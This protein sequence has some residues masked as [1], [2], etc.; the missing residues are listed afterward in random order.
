MASAKAKLGK[1]TGKS[2]RRASASR[3]APAS[4]ARGRSSAESRGS[5]IRDLEGKAAAIDRAQAVIEFD[6]QGNVLTANENFLATLGYELS[7]IQG[8]HHRV[9]CD[10]AYVATAEYAAL[11]QKLGRGEYD[12]G[13]YRRLGKGGKEIWIQASYNPVLGADGKPWK[14][15]K[16]ATDVTRQKTEAVEFECK[17]A[18]IDKAQ[19]IIEFDLQGHV[20][21]ANQNFLAT[22]GYELSEIQGKHH[23]MFCDPEYV[24]TADYA[25]FW[26][27]LGRGEHDGGVYRRIGKGGKEVWIHASYNPIFDASGRPY[28]VV[29]FA[30]DITKQQ[31]FEIEAVRTQNMVDSASTNIIL[32][33]RDLNVQYLNPAS[34]KI[35]KTLEAFLPVKVEDMLGKSIDIFHKHPEHQRRLLSDPKNLPHRADIQVGPE[36]LSLLVSAITDAEGKYIGPMLTWEVVTEQRAAD[37]AVRQLIEAATKGR[38]DERA[39]VSHL[40]GSYRDLVAGVNQMLDGIVQPLQEGIEVLDALSRGDLTRRVAGDYQGDL[41]RMKTSINNSIANLAQMVEQIRLASDTIAQGSDEISKGNHDL[42]QRMEEQASSLEETAASMEQMSGTIQQNADNSKQANQLAIQCRGIA[43]KGG[44]VVA[45]AVSSMGEINT[46]SKKIADIIGVIDEIAFQTNLLALNAA[47]EA[48]RAGEQGRGF[49][50]VAAEVRNLAQRSATAAK[51]I[52]TLIQ[53]SVQKVQEG[54]GLVNESG[55]TLEEIVASVK[56]VADIIGEISAASQ[57]QASG[58][59]QVNKAV[60]QLDQITQQNAA[61]VEQ[62]AAASLAMADQSQAL[63]SE[64]GRLQLDSESERRLSDKLLAAARS[65]T[66]SKKR[67]SPGNGA[68]PHG[69]SSQTAQDAFE[70]F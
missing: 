18:A 39:D 33:D 53:D 25:A 3:G 22:L 17:L 23:R 46:S 14:I 57:E 67:T 21:T 43:E 13:V 34:K 65:T 51:E 31:K 47:V 10:P 1:K 8:Q 9:F 66:A 12:A 2:T 36:K 69:A 7:E 5:S 16:F 30:S 68:I 48:A 35:L 6:L 56:R 52:K 15:I 49:A 50:V 61:L 20:L 27:K 19:A 42:S 60:T 38:L 4:V 70:E 40:T 62:T 29:K 58:V 11:W 32:C 64:V 63:R 26:Q 45:R 41:D 44:S 28:K 24:T 59:E 54:S 37:A 55:S